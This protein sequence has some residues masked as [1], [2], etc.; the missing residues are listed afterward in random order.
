DA[1][2]EPAGIALA[3]AAAV[4]YALYAVLCKRL[5]RLGLA[6][7]GVMG[8]SFGLAALLLV[9]VLAAAGPGQLAVPAG[10]GVALYLGLLPTAAAYL[11]Y[12]RGLRRVSAGEATTIGLSEPL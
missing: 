5:L 1:G 12:A 10:L 3:V 6:P 4:G 2:I 11:L 8:A 9:P 7:G